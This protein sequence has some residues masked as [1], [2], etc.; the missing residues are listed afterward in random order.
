[1]YFLRGIPW[2]LELMLRLLYLDGYHVQLEMCMLEIDAL[3]VL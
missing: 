2:I 3:A 1:M